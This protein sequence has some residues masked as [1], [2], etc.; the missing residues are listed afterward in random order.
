MSKTVGGGSP[1]SPQ[2]RTVAARKL[3]TLTLI[4]ATFFMVSGGPF[5]LEE[6]LSNAGYLPS[7]LVLIIVPIT[8]C[9]PTALMVSELSAA[10]PV[11][12][13]YYVW[14]MRALG[15][16]WGFQEAW[17]S[18]A[19]SIFDMALY[20][21]VFVLYASKLFPALKNPAIGMLTGAIV[22][23]VCAAWNL[24]GVRKVGNSA[25]VMAVVLRKG[26]SRRRPSRA[27]WKTPAGRTFGLCSSR[28]YRSR[29]STWCQCSPAGRQ[30]STPLGGRRVVGRTQRFRW[31]ARGY[32]LGSCSEG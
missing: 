12:G 8:W 11:D 5:G 6:L 13:G 14:V 29:S 19:S 15:P 23:A 25:V 20:P 18:L 26:H 17:L 7:V 4:A 3:T 28:R 16:F 30:A 1:S 2:I 9:F 10:I 24:S 22:I 21:T 32:F 27:R 31:G